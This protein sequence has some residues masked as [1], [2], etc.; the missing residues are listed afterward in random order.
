MTFEYLTFLAVT[1]NKHLFPFVLRSCYTF[2]T[3]LNI[4]AIY[5]FDVTRLSGNHVSFEEPREQVTHQRGKCKTLT[6]NFAV[7]KMEKV[8][9][10]S[11][12]R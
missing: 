9:E 3:N 1:S 6:L 8:V 4:L 12:H 7:V 11:I 10:N 5:S 2:D